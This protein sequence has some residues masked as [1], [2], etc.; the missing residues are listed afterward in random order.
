MEEKT[1]KEKALEKLNN[2]SAKLEELKDQVNSDSNET[3]NGF[4]AQKTK[5]NKWINVAKD[6]LADTEVISE[7]KAA[8][9]K[10]MLVELKEKALVA[11]AETEDT[12]DTQ[13]KN[14]SKNLDKLKDYLHKVYNDSQDSAKDISEE[15]LE[16][17][18]DFH[19][20]FDAFK[21]KMS[22]D[23][24]GTWEEKK[25]EINEKLNELSAKM[26]ESEGEASDKWEDVSKEL[27]EAWKHV[28]NAFKN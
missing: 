15:A 2:W 28:R 4:E 18:D 14:L 20:K 24:E 17:L 19:A 1:L 25:K 23:A 11:K 10:E 22:K 13:H 7:D 8:E 6:K 26:K 3:L 16:D 9:I 12:M 21:L 5:L 27:S